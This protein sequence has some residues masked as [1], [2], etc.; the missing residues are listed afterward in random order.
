MRFTLKNF[1]YY[2]R[3]GIYLIRN[4]FNAIGEILSCT[5]ELKGIINILPNPEILLKAVILKQVRT[6]S[7][8]SD[9]PRIET[10]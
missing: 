7:N 2:P 1:Q 9:F 10:Q 5:A 8:R 3:K 4:Y 6:K